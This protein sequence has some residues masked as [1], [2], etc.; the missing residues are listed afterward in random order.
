[1]P[2]TQLAPGG[3]SAPLL[4]RSWPRAILHIDCDA[5][6]ASC[7]QALHPE[8]RGKPV[9]T[10]KERGIV[11]AASYE[12]KARGV[13]RGVP[14][15]EVKKLCPDA[16]ILPSDYETYSI[17]SKRMFAIIRRFSPLVEE[18]SID[19]AFV[20]ITGLRRLY[21][22]SYLTITQHIKAAIEGELG[23][24]VS[25]GLSL[26]KVLAKIGSKHKK[27]AGLTAIPGREV[28]RFLAELPVDKLWGIGA[29]TAAYCGTLGIRTA[30]DFASKP[31]SYIEGHFT[32]PHIEMWYELNGQAVYKI[33]TE[34][35]TT[36]GTI[37]K[38]KT[39]TPP[40]TDREYVY[41]QLFKNL[42]N[43][44]IKARRHNLA[45]KGLVLYLKQ[46]DFSGGGVEARLSRPSAFPHDMS[47]LTR[48][49]FN[50]I[51]RPGQLYRA[52]GVILTGLVS[53]DTTQQSLFEPPV[54]L[55]KLER[56]YQAIDQLAAKWGKHCVHM[57]GSDGAHGT[58]QHVLERG[59]VTQRKLTR[60][61]GESKRK[62]LAL[63][64]LMHRLT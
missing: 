18:Y 13:T 34:E 54:R 53:A 61:T 46:Q 6:F 49:L 28:H 35:K 15:W 33:A 2:H 30:L 9:V 60:L 19:E 3:S 36:Y 37:S 26:S 20:D 31:L 57:A 58:P 5:F 64:M 29:N 22:A 38:T 7:E 47:G 32:K 11:A 16:I 25:I 1:M 10:G 44:C 50:K 24:T 17:F 43:A 48:E 27:P 41:A 12:A 45:A 40:S 8:Y 42:E 39:F 14:L 56:V 23:I 59:D 51:Y 21:H 63:P 55:E 4:V 62:H 52:T